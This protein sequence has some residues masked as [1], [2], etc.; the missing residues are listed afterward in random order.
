MRSIGLIGS[1]AVLALSAPLAAQ[2]NKFRTDDPRSPAR[3]PATIQ[4]QQ[5]QNQQNRGDKIPPGQLPPAGMCRIWIDGVPP[6]RQPAPTDCQTAVANKPAN[7]RILWGDQAAFPGK[8]KS[9][10]KKAHDGQTGTVLGSG[11]AR[12]DN[13]QGD[14]NDNDDDDR[15]ASQRVGRGT[16]WPTS[17]SGVSASRGQ[18]MKSLKSKKGKGHGDD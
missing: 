12:G 8:G 3:I 4:N 7:A 15:N 18:S 1:F 5:N 6:G 9:K 16:T 2:S 11:R 17:T 14:E 10:V 13:E